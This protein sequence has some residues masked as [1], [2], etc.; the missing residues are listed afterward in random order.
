[1]T[2][3]QRPK[4]YLA[5]NPDNLPPNSILNNFRVAD[6][7]KPPPHLMRLFG[8]Y[9]EKEVLNPTDLPEISVADFGHK[10]LALFNYGAHEDHKAIPV[11]DWV[12]EVA[13]SPYREVKLM[14]EVDGGYGEVARIPPLFD[15]LQP[16][17]KEDSRDYFVGMASMQA[18]LHGS[19]NRT[20]EANGFIKRNLTD[21][22]E[23]RQE[24]TRNFHRMSEIFKM[25]GVERVIPDWIKQLEGYVGDNKE[26][27]CTRCC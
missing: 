15:R 26:N 17:F 9:V 3:Q 1:M 21:R 22:I 18:H 12:Q 19:V 24:L 8:N 7:A 25:Y 4:E 11:M 6:T 20:D 2:N 10:W 16:F 23:Y 13:G 27:N 5:P 14:G